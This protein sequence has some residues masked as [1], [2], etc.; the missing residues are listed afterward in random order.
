MGQ[1]YEAVEGDSRCNR[2]PGRGVQLNLH[3]TAHQYL[4]DVLVA[5][6][7]TYPYSGLIPNTIAIK[8]CCV[9]Y[10][11]EI[12]HE[13][14]VER[15]DWQLSRFDS[16]A[17]CFYRQAAAAVADEGGVVFGNAALAQSR[18]KPQSFNGQY[19]SRLNTESLPQP[20]GLSDNNADLHN[21]NCRI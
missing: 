1:V 13:R 5:P 12:A 15:N 4:V 14:P 2:Q 17:N 7:A 19:P 3:R 9:I 11:L 10:V 18:S 20:I 21:T 16:N 6:T 8:N